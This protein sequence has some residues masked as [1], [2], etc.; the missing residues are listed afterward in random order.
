MTLDELPT[1]TV[2]HVGGDRAVGV[3]DRAIWIG[4]R[5][6]GDLLLPDGRFVAGRF[7]NVD[8]ASLSASF[9]PTTP[10]EL[11][12][13]QVGEGYRR[14]DGYWGERAALVLDRSRRW[15]ERAFE[16][17][18]AVAYKRP[19]DTLIAK[20]SNQNLPEGSTPIKG[21][22]DHEHCDVCWETVSPHAQPVAMF[23][24]PD[25]W[26]CRRCYEKFVVPRSLDFIFIE[27]CSRAPGEE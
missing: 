26:I 6:V 13:L 19:G 2:R 14:F 10:D 11:A 27:E 25:H 22:W 9:V 17:A 1:F 5:H 23:S 16:T 21:G 12:L 24:E 4:E 3:V 15:K 8:L 18:D 7:L 20:A